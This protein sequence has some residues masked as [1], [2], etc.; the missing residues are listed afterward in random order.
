MSVLEALNLWKNFGATIALRDVNLSLDKGFHVI[1]GPNGSGKSTLLKIWSGLLRPSRGSVRTLGLNPWVERSRVLRR[2]HV[3]FEDINLPWW[4]T[5]LDYL[6]HVA[7]T[8]GVKWSDVV[9]LAEILGVTDY[10][11]KGIR[12]YSSGMRKKVLLL[13]ALMGE[14]DIMILDEPYTLLDVR[15]V[16]KLQEIIWGK[17]RSGVTVVIATHIFTNLEDKADTLTILRN[18]VIL[19]HH[20]VNKLEETARIICEDKSVV[21][22]IVGSITGNIERVIVEEGSISLIA[23]YEGLRGDLLEKCRREISLRDVYE[24]EL[25]RSS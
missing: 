6:K 25:T 11:S 16:T 23:K 12:G 18:G 20:N 10:W 2:V 15:S 14:P 8:R 17:V 19:A 3:A 24:K 22:E 5:G 13:Q 4:T 7:Y 21:S 1:A 9:E